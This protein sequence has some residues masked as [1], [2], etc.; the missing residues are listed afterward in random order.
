[1]HR[2]D[3]PT[4]QVTRAPYLATWPH[5]HAGQ[6]VFLNLEDWGFSVDL[7]P[8][9]ADLAAALAPT[10]AGDGPTP[11]GDGP[12]P[13]G[14]GPTPA[15][16]G[17]ALPGPAPLEDAAPISLA[18]LVD[19][20][21][22]DARPYRPWGT[23][24]V[25]RSR[26]PQFGLVFLNERFFGSAGLQLA[27]RD[28]LGFHNW[29]VSGLWNQTTGRTDLRVGWLVA[30]LAPWF[31][32]VQGTDFWDALLVQPENEPWQRLWRQRDRVA[33]VGVARQFHLA[34]FEF[35]GMVRDIERRTLRTLEP[36]PLPPP[37]DPPP[38]PLSEPPPGPPLAADPLGGT[39]AGAYAA[40]RTQAIQAT[41][42][43][44]VRGGWVFQTLGA[45]YQ[46][47]VPDADAFT[48]LGASLRLFAP[49]PG[50]RRH[51][52]TL[53]SNVRTL[54][55]GAPD[56]LLRVGGVAP[57]GTFFE[58]TGEGRPADRPVRGVASF[59]QAARGFEPVP[60]IGNRTVHGWLGWS[61]P[62]VI[63]RG[64]GHTLWIL[65]S[66]VLNE[67]RFDAFGAVRSMLDGGTTDAAVGGGASLVF[68]LLGAPL[69]LRY[70]YS[71]VLE[72]LTGQGHFLSFGLF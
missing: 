41:P 55:G 54:V 9:P 63:D 49:V 50:T 3:G 53:Q 51:Q 22:L 2:L 46:P 10:P 58:R 17:T 8:L 37:T 11:A 21:V 33:L 7:Q 35:G 57:D 29:D 16:D 61:V 66:G 42:F 45:W 67:I 43:G 44:G 13:H 39:F 25:P 38:D 23:L 19:D 31:I 62:I 56:G 5:V 34:G 28:E 64:V 4:V 59:D 24:F 71:R 1:L 68:S 65:P 69:A 26:I 36:A 18:P 60:R 47:M 70:Q 72:G 15:G 6:V 30:A 14:D 52:L 32:G 40:F 12:T 27:G 20:P 48:D